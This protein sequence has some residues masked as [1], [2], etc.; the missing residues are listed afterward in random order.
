MVTVSVTKS[1]NN[2]TGAKLIARHMSHTI[3]D[4]QQ[5]IEHVS[6]KLPLTTLPKIC[7]SE[8]KT[9]DRHLIGWPSAEK[10]E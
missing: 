2:A 4:D 3:R 7:T 6:T 1:N 9:N 10:Y 5:R 8:A